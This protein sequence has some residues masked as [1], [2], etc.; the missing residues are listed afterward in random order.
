MVAGRRFFSPVGPLGLRAG[1]H[2]LLEVRWLRPEDSWPEAAHR[3]Q[4]GSA[5]LARAAA[6]L[7]RYFAGEP[8]PDLPLDISPLRR[9]QRQ[10][11]TTLRASVP[12]GHVI[13][14]AEL[15]ALAGY[16]GAARAVG[17]VM[18][19]NPLPLFVPCHRVVGAQGP[20]GFGPGLR[21]KQA[22]LRHEG[23]ELHI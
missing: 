21:V 4:A 13:T 9:F 6:A 23:F 7:D 17:G 3:P 8:L 1:D 5:L 15:A 10:V 19:R 20:G 22:L 16:P 18:A 11:L 12:P 14:Y 2:G